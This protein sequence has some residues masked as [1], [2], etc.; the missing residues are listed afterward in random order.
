M[1]NIN[2]ASTRAKNMRSMSGQLPDRSQRAAIV[3]HLASN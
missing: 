3:E 1:A 2:D